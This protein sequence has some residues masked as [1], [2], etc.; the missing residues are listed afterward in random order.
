MLLQL[1]KR[2]QLLVRKLQNKV[3]SC[4]TSCKFQI[5]GIE[6]SRRDLLA[7]AK[8]TQEKR[9]LTSIRSGYCL[10]MTPQTV[11]ESV[12]LPFIKPDGFSVLDNLSHDLKNDV[13][14]FIHSL[15]RCFSDLPTLFAHVS[16]DSLAENVPF[17]P[18]MVKPRD[19]LASS[20]LPAL[21]GH[22]WSVELRKSY[23]DFLINIAK[24]L[25]QT[26]FLNIREH[27]LFECFKN[28][29]HASNIH[30][31][32][33]LSIGDAMLQLVRENT[34]KTPRLTS[35]ANDMVMRMRANISSFPN[36][37]RLLLKK[38]AD[39]APDDTQR[40]SRIEILF[41]D[42]ILAPAI[43][44]PKAYSVLPPTFNLD[45]SA[46]GPARTLQHLAQHFRLIL[47]PEAAQLR[48][49]AQNDIGYLQKIPLGEFLNQ[50]VD[51]NENDE[52][53]E[54]G[55]PSLS[56]MMTLLNTDSTFL[57]FTMSDIYLLAKLLN[58]HHFHQQQM[59]STTFLHAPKRRMIFLMT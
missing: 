39:L 23:I 4:D 1:I 32:L 40:L 38:F 2:D 15:Y 22:C 18:T 51:V 56:E 13:H 33:K 48:N 49:I 9:C 53:F 50:L 20:T 6:A 25:P 26:V 8:L 36:D 14:A 47:H 57:L 12:K 19:F 11:R 3:E 31:F 41:I 58:F 7:K 27:W 54:I 52:L 5:A 30:H 45:M 17:L 59:V 24:Q 46:T 28:Y 10:R 43:S 37:I 44:L 34:N 16:S 21:F 35:Y 29:I 55:G 42:C